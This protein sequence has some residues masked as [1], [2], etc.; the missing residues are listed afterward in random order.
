MPS[1]FLQIT[2]HITCI[3]YIL[4]YWEFDVYIV[5]DHASLATPEPKMNDKVT[6]AC[7]WNGLCVACWVWQLNKAHANCSYEPFTVFSF[8]LF[9]IDL[10]GK[11]QAKQWSFTFT[12]Y[13]MDLPSKC[14]CLW[15][16]DKLVRGTWPVHEQY[17]IHI[18]PTWQDGIWHTSVVVF[19]QEF[20]YGQGIL[21]SSPGK[22]STFIVDG[23]YS[24]MGC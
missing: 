18:V 11:W 20:Y 16:G 13:P 21:T 19:G 17:L 5:R 15:Q 7:R 22:N 23:I 9:R 1:I 4:L 2:H 6:H 8:S 3:L 14:Q 12:T 24:Y 10:F